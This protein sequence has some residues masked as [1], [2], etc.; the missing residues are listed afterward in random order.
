MRPPGGAR[1]GSCA[2]LAV[3]ICS[4][5]LRA[6]AQ[7]VSA[8][9]ILSTLRPGHPRLLADKSGFAA[10]RKRVSEDDLLRS[11]HRKLKERGRKVLEEK[12][13]AYELPDG[14]RLLATSRKVLDRIYLL[15][16]LY[17]LDGDRAYA[18][19]AWRELEAAA[20]FPDWNPR[21]F[22]DT[23]EM[24][25]AFAIGYD[26]LYDA[27][28]AK[29]RDTIRA[30][31]IAKGLEPAREA[32]A[33]RSD[34]IAWTKAVNNWNQVCNAG[35]GIGALAVAEE[36]PRLSE[37][38][39]RKA[40]SLLPGAMARYAPDGAWAEGPGYWHY[41][42]FYSVVFIAA[43][44][45]AMGTDFALSE[46]PGFRETGAFPIHMT[47]PTGRP[48]NFADV[49]GDWPIRAPELMWLAKRFG[50]RS[51]LDYEVAAAAP[52]PL[53]LLWYGASPAPPRPAGQPPLDRRFRGADAASFRGAWN[54]PDAVF[55]AFKGGDNKASHA[56]L[57]L[58][59]FVL[60]A[61]G[62]RWAI[63]LGS[64]DY[65]LPGYFGTKRWDYYRLR[66][67]GHNTLVIRGGRTGPALDQDPGAAGT[68]TRFVSRPE[69]AFAVLDLTPAYSGVARSVRRGLALIGRKRV[70]IQDEVA[71]RGEAE[72]FWF[73]HTRAEIEIG[74]DRRSA[75][76]SLGA[77]RL[78]ARLLSPPDG[79]FSVLDA[80]PLPSS[81]S[82]G[83]QNGNAGVR[84][85]AVR[86][87]D[88]RDVRLVVDL[89]PLAEGRP[90]PSNGDG[91]SPLDRWE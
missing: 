68:V 42:T 49:S 63:D 59:T 76:L 15:A 54:D 90:A 41:A 13:A 84:R 77:R 19:R 2:L 32:Y 71:T 66:A 67:E 80:A 69:R 50:S 64:D 85:L 51:F 37:Y 4:A 86:L 79:A 22:L 3:L 9:A 39:L 26:W 5:A 60:D 45:S 14:L 56:H 81:P 53:D 1:L 30:A 10:L 16:L 83:G 58:G 36:E 33:G 8:S 52:H 75:T 27:W 62:K 20:R 25:H 35:I 70:R 48:F 11:W 91:I 87:D 18:D 24:V 74:A 38:L 40:L 21:H 88:V 12:P 55:L 29:Q 34:A 6:P 17:R 44:D 89:I 61:L 7:P 57:D 82:P 46:S 73:L 28:T 43:L 23:A 47:G 72:V 65:N 31:M 78:L